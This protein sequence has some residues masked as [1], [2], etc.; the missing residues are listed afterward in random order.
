MAPSRKPDANMIFEWS[1]ACF[2]F[3]FSII[4]KAKQELHPMGD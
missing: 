2:C 3:E 1:E 4:R